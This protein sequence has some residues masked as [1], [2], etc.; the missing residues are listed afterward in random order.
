MG[1]IPAL[2]RWLGFGGLLPQL[3]SVAVLAA[4]PPEW[5]GTAQ[6]IA[7]LYAALIFAF[8]GGTWWGIAAAAPAAERRRALGWLWIAAVTPGLVALAL[9]VP[10]M[11]GEAPREPS[12]MM[13]GAA[14]LLS[15]VVD[16]KLGPLAPRW[17]FGLRIRLSLALGAATL[18]AALA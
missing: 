18:A 13:L 3:A 8:L 12:L 16:A 6:A 2:P 4:G 14:I 15:P 9:L 11:L 5:R 10:P 17:W 7:L 1:D